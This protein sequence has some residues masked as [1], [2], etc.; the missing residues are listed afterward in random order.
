MYV[1]NLAPLP[2]LPWKVVKPNIEWFLSCWSVSSRS[3]HFSLPHLLWSRSV[4]LVKEGWGGW[5]WERWPN[6]SSPGVKHTNGI[7]G[8]V[9]AAFYFCLLLC[10]PKNSRPRCLVY[11]IFK[12]VLTLVHGH[13]S[14]WS[15]LGVHIEQLL[16]V[17]GS[18]PSLPAA[19]FSPPSSYF[20]PF[21]PI[22]HIPRSH[23]FLCLSFHVTYSLSHLL[24]LLDGQNARRKL[25]KEPS[26]MAD[27]KM[28]YLKLM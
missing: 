15:N 17:A 8:N 23:F 28:E 10:H 3:G 2:S 6:P 4:L 18:I 21:P 27:H 25:R 9:K 12:F 14:P 19:Y 20:N 5:G 7:I 1:C 16:W 22:A 11:F 26:H 13:R 24:L